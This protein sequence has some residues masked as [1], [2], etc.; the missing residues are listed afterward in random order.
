M[1]DFNALI[2]KEPVEIPVAFI[3][4]WNLKD[5]KMLASI[6][7]EDAEF[8]NVT[9]L[10]WH[11]RN[12]IFK[13]H[14]YGLK[15]IFKDSELSLRKTK[16]KYL[17]DTVAV[18]NAR[19]HLEG[20]TSIDG[21]KAQA[22]NTIFTFVV[23]QNEDGN[24]SCASAQNTDVVPGKETHIIDENGNMEGVDYRPNNTD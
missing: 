4:A 22:R 24:W 1:A 2:L 17:S 7:D 3:K 11:D 14:D 19:M 5:A 8:I 15:V 9:G 20:Q 6:F 18:V 13:A 16:V 10:W 12:A 21:K 23:H